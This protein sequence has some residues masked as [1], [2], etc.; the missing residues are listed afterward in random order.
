MAAKPF[1]KAPL[2]MPR[3]G[4]LA[5]NDDGA[6]IMTLANIASDLAAMVRLI[7]AIELQK[8]R[9]RIHGRD[10]GV[11]NDVTPDIAELSR[12]H[13]RFDLGERVKPA[14]ERKVSPRGGV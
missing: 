12:P 2:K 7:D 10:L 9:L 13:T 1:D 4:R 8:K 11:L 14:L 5:M 6:V 3:I